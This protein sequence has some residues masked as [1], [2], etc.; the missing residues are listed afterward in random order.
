MIPTFLAGRM[1]VGA[2]LGFALPNVAE[3]LDRRMAQYQQ[4]AASDLASGRAPPLLMP[5]GPGLGMQQPP[6]F[7]G[8]P[9]PAPPN[10]AWGPP[11]QYYAPPASASSSTAA[12]AATAAPGGRPTSA[13]ASKQAGAVG[14]KGRAPLTTRAAPQA[15][16]SSARR[17]TQTQREPP[18]PPPL[19]DPPALDG[20]Y[21]CVCC[22]LSY[23]FV[24]ASMAE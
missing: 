3:E 18:P 10:V 15:R 8:Y 14:S 23:Q 13:P 20:T 6:P 2:Q 24:T 11:M 22:A 4:L 7:Y 5:F 16:S 17:K 19:P 1:Q 12:A 9:E 21:T